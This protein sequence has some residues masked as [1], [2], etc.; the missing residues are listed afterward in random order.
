MAVAI[1]ARLNAGVHASRRRPSPR[2]IGFVGFFYTCD[3]VISWPD[4][5]MRLGD[6]SAGLGMCGGGGWGWPGSAQT[7]EVAKHAVLHLL[8]GAWRGAGVVS[9]WQGLLLKLGLAFPAAPSGVCGGGLH[10]LLRG[11]VALAEHQ[12]D[13]A[14]ELQPSLGHAR[15]KGCANGLQGAG[16]CRTSAGP[17]SRRRRPVACAKN[18]A[19]AGADG[20]SA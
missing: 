7:S 1:R 9:G 20:S 2:Q 18:R 16:C 10:K 19:R 3:R 15:L 11:E 14:G 13:G 6:L 5:S 17:A 12:Q 4:M 8:A